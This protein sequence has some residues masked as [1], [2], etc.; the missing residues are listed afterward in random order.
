MKTICPHCKQE[1]PETPDEYL[2]MTLQ[3]SVCQKEF[4]CEKAK[5]CSE[6]GNSSHAKALKCSQCGKFFPTIPTPQQP[7]TNTITPQDNRLNS[8]N[9]SSDGL[10]DDCFWEDVDWFTAW[11]KFG[12]F[13][14]RSRPKELILFAISMLIINIIATLIVPEWGPVLFTI[15]LLASIPLDIRR[16]HD[17]G[18]SGWWL[19][20]PFMWLVLPFIPSQHGANQYGPNSVN[21]EHNVSAL[22]LCSVIG[23]VWLII[24]PA[25][26][27]PAL[28]NSRERAREANCA[29]NLKQVGAAI[30]MFAMDNKDKTPSDLQQLI[31]DGYL[32][33]G[34]TDRCPSSS[35]QYV[36]L[37]NGLKNGQDADIPVAMDRPDNHKKRINV[38][39]MGG[40]VQRHELS[41]ET[42]SCVA[43][44]NDLYPHLAGSA[45]GRTV[46]ENAKKADAGW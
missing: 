11:K 19:L 15:S 7:P 24:L 21:N 8:K 4:I 27:L 3:C 40:Y 39:Y 23:L 1:Y 12:I 33:G 32:S 35:R 43:V 46:L 25:C 41:K 22:K 30:T 44:L 6:C 38:L 16:L 45:A 36:Y 13:S 42:N 34:D 28:Q 14:G 20:S 9:N 17:F 10:D 18:M 5:F 29:S 31:A 26:L 2:G 37:G